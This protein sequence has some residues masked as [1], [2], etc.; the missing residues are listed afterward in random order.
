[1]T[2][3]DLGLVLDWEPVK[4]HGHRGIPSAQ[5]LCGRFAK[6]LGTRHAHGGYGTIEVMTVKCSRCGEQD[7]RLT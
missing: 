6:Y 1:M 4:Q 5:C 7:V 3:E 2:F